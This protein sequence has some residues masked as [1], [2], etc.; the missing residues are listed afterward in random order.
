[1]KSSPR[2]SNN[3][4]K[5]NETDTPSSPETPS[6]KKRSNNK[7]LNNNNK[8]SKETPQKKRETK[9]KLE[10]IAEEASD[11]P[12]DSQHSPEELAREKYE[13]YS[14]PLFLPLFFFSFLI[15]IEI[16]LF[17]IIC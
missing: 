4:K 6:P 13:F 12:I 1:M 2:K 17:D 3:T 15:K 7:Q 14:L 11:S 10:M 8:T 9:R 5:R 16:Y